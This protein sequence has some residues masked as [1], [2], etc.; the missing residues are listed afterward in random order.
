[1]I[2]NLNFKAS[3][4]SILNFFQ[5]WIFISSYTNFEFVNIQFFTPSG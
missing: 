3:K 2:F 4:I 5:A 1:M